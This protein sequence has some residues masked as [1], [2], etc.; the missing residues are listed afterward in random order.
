MSHSATSRSRIEIP[1]LYYIDEDVGAI[2]QLTASLN[3][4]TIY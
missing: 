2:Q 3:F 4:W 1:K